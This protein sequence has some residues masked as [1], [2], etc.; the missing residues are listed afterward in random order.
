MV[1]FAQ[2]EMVRLA[3]LEMSDKKREGASI[4]SRK[5]RDLD[6]PRHMNPKIS[7]P[8]AVTSNGQPVQNGRR[9]ITNT[10]RKSLNISSSVSL[11]G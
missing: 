3:I 11:Q 2:K 4:A 1:R 6:E 5:S 7:A 8:S 9:S 10:S